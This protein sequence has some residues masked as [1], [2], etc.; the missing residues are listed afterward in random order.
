MSI[1][2]SDVKKNINNYFNNNDTVKLLFGNPVILSLIIILLILFIFS[3][4]VY[5]NSDPYTY[6]KQSKIIIYTYIIIF[7]CIIINNSILL[8]DFNN[9]SKLGGYDKF[10]SLPN[11]NPNFISSNSINTNEINNLNLQ[12]I[13]KLDVDTFLN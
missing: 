4:Q 5:N 2:T 12:D 8:N 13:G 7:V 11:D 9:L 3:I 6:T 1:V 10:I